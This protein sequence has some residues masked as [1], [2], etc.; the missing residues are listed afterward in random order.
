MPPALTPESSLRRLRPLWIVG[1]AFL[2]FTAIPTAVRFLTDWFWF[3][4]VG[5][6]TVFAT[7]IVTKGALFLVAGLVAYAFLAF[8]VRMA[9]GGVSRTPVLWRVSPDL[10]P[11]D[12]AASLS[13]IAGPVAAVFSLLFALTATGD[14]MEVLQ[15]LNRSEFGVTDPIFRRDIGSYV[16]VLPALA[17]L[18]GMMRG[19]VIITLL[20]VVVLHALRGR[21]TLPPQRVGLESPAAGHVA[22]LLVGFLVITALQIWLVRIPELLYSNTGPFT[23]ASYSDLNARYPALHI[24]AITSII[25]AALIAYGAVRKKIVWFAFLAAASYVVVSFVAGGLYPWAVQRFVVTPTELTREAPQLRNHI[26]ASRRAWGLDSIETRDLTGD[27][28]LSLQDIRANAATIENVRLWDRAPL[29]RTFGQLQEIR[30]YYDFVS[31]DDDRYLINGRYRQV[32]LS[33]RELNT[34]SLPTRNFVNQH[35]T[36][37]HGMGLTL[38][39]VNEVTVEG[40]PVL[41]IKDLPPVSNVSLQVTRPQIYY[42][43][44]TDDHVFVNT[45]QPEFDYPSGEA[46]ISTR[47][48]GA[49]GVRV[50]G[51]FKRALFAMRF[52]ALNILLSGDIRGDSR[53]LYNRTI[54][55]RAH[56]AMPFLSFDADPYLVIAS[57]GQLKWI[58]DAYTSTD[59]YPYSQPLADGTSYMR[60]S[61]KVVI[62]AYDGSIQPYI[63]DPRDPLI[64]TYSRIFKGIMK[65][66]SAFPA[67]LRPH[68]RYPSDLFNVQA[69][70]YATFHMDAAETFYHR[71]DQWQIPNVGKSANDEAQFMRH[72]VMR[73]PEERNAEYIFMVPFT[74]RGKDNLASWM[75]VRNDGANYGKLR[76][77]R[78]PK[79]SLVYGPRQIIARIDQNTEISRELTLW[80]QVGSEVIRGELLVIPI[81]EAL[82]YVQPIYL[83]AE[84]GRIPELKRVVVA[85]EN[86]V[87]MAETLEAGLGQMFG[88][89]VPRPRDAAPGATP[90]PATADSAQTPAAVAAA[91]VGGAANTTLIGEARGHYDRAIAAQRAGDW[92]VYGS[93]IKALGDVLTR[94]RSGATR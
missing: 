44:L 63:A 93:E 47:Y 49:G 36:F 86:R 70:L 62:D 3:Q 21:V 60:N 57:N 20:I 90:T 87:V 26:R 53:V 28:Q 40:L 2:V 8:N 24:V 16:F 37:T 79:Q 34:E 55:R 10:P 80:N 39:P 77:Y 11:V 6:E 54:L 19:L 82:I 61:V 92:A 43:E 1:F 88:G 29:L 32:M 7:Q 74:P 9:S 15:F 18:L 50:G 42:G 17:S 33:P 23:G 83:Q 85:Y 5:F 72:L 81:G 41:F 94:L 59:R 52:G 45:R 73:L 75:V 78:F 69:G 58:L 25:G 76:V 51:L 35:L 67:E 84:G 48:N 64:R 65:P 89:N 30:T 13:R 68:V 31:V 22:A 27:A 4:E 46:N 66:M 14:W 91:P 38:G 56:L 71:E 12:I